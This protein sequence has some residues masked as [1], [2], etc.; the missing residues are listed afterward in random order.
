M[1][2]SKE[3]YKV[4]S[5]INSFCER[6]SGVVIAS[7]LAVIM[8]FPTQQFLDIVNYLD[9]ESLVL[10]NKQNHAVWMTPLGVE[11]LKTSLNSPG[12]ASPIN[13]NLN[14][15]G[16]NLGPIQQGGQNNTQNATINAQFNAKIQELL[17]LIDVTQELSPVQKL[18]A[19]N[20][21]R[22]VHELSRLDTTQEV[23]EEVRSRL[24]NVT[25]VIS[26]SADLVSLGMP[27]I[28]IIR[29]FFGV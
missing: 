13:Y 11:A 19:V 15:H 5:A 2:L 27:I 18:K 1:K 21:I 10:F 26:L 14:I 17:N 8:D 28:Q 9:S 12:T 24:D 4:L 22:T 3:N 6:G 7:K 25:S 23:Q 29:A 20:D 16:D